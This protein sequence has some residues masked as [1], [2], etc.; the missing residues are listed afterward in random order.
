MSAF[1][2]SKRSAKINPIALHWL[3]STKPD[4]E[5]DTF[6]EK[7]SDTTM[8]QLRIDSSI[9]LYAIEWEEQQYA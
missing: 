1:E 2:Q 9:V 4:A 7:V 6:E 5:G 3:L 8:R